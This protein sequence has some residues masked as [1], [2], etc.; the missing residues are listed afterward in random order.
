MTVSTVDEF[1]QRLFPL[2]ACGACFKGERLGDHRKRS[3]PSSPQAKLPL[4][5]AAAGTSARPAVMKICP[6][7]RAPQY[8]FSVSSSAALRPTSGWRPPQSFSELPAELQLHGRLRQFQ[9]LQV[10][11]GGDEFDALDFGPDHAVDGIAAPTTHT[12]NLIFAG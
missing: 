10:G 7:L 9:R 11:I 6:S 5:G 8:I 3:V 12:D 1:L 4:R 2:A